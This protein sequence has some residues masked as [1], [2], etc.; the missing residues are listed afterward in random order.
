MSKR[1]YEIDSLR[2][3]AFLLLI[4][5]HAGMVF[6][7]WDFYLKNNETS[8]WFDTPMFFSHQWRLPLLFIISG[9][10]T[11]F[12]ISRRSL[13]GFAGER[14]RRLF[15]P[16]IFGIIVVIPPQVYFERLAEGFS[17]SSYW[18]YYIHDA[19]TKGF[20]D[21]GRGG[22][23]SWHHL[24]FIMYLFIYSMV[25]IILKKPL[26]F[27]SP[28][29]KKMTY[30]SKGL[31][32]FLFLCIP[33]FLCEYFLLP[34]F[35]GNRALRSDWYILIEFLF[36]F[37]CGYL[38]ARNINDIWP[39]FIKSKY[40]TLCI[41]IISYIIYANLYNLPGYEFLKAILRTL[42]VWCMLFAIF[43]FAIQYLNKKSKW[44]SYANEAVYPFYILHQTAII[45]IMYYI[46]NWELNIFVKFIIVVVGTTLICWVLY[47][48]IIR[49]IGVLR[50]LFG[51]KPR[52]KI[53]SK[54]TPSAMQD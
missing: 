15:I 53:V 39:I 5:F 24:W 35:P 23:I 7:P 6:V 52:T 48:F 34:H 19:F 4:L 27:F 22:N 8:I 31:G 37:L 2:V 54:P 38:I 49:K 30:L 33:V 50:F 28:Y 51:M 42:N 11:Y 44:I 18:D 29:L 32:V 20:Y 16:L 40:L 3:Y 25:L 41:G 45:G 21:N 36:F 12:S 47:H 14:F 17:Y 46:R 43:G 1:Y 10:G 26:D 9:I 13:K